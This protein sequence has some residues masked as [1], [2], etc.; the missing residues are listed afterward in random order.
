[1]IG[2]IKHCFCQN[3]KNHQVTAQTH[4]PSTTS[5]TQLCDYADI[6]LTRDPSS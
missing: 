3:K 4:T 1:M 6:N 2:Y 5:L